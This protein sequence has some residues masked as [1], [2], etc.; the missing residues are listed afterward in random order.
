MS[1]NREVLKVVILQTFKYIPTTCTTTNNLNLGRENFEEMYN[2]IILESHVLCNYNLTY[3]LQS[4]SNHMRC[5]VVSL[6]GP[7]NISYLLEA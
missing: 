7:K 5:K 6:I 2:S 3:F 4:W 1:K